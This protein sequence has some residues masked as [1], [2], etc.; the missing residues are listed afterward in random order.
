MLNQ[1][2]D[3]LA[4]ILENEKNINCKTTLTIDELSNKLKQS[5]NASSDLQNQLNAVK[6]ELDQV[7]VR[8]QQIMQPMSAWKI[9]SDTDLAAINLI[10]PEARKKPFFLRPLSNLISFLKNPKNEELS[11]PLGPEE[12]FKLRESAKQDIYLKLDCLLVSRP[13]LNISINTLKDSTWNQG[14]TTTNIVEFAEAIEECAHF[15]K[16]LLHTPKLLQL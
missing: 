15:L 14:N 6:Q 12:W 1:E 3:T 5:Q 7:E 4:L 2:V 9:A 11:S 8:L 10:F 16:S 13:Y